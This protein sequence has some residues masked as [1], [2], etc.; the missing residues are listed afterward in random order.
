MKAYFSI[1]VDGNFEFPDDWAMTR[2]VQEIV[3]ATTER[4]QDTKV[5]N[6]SLRINATEEAKTLK[7]VTADGQDH[8]IV[9]GKD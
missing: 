2:V 7:I 6:L 1:T 8:N 3:D 9:V 5:S 4:F